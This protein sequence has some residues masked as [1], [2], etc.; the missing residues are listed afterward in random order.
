MAYGETYKG[1]PLKDFNAG[2]KY[3]MNVLRWI[4]YSPQTILER[5]EAIE[6]MV[7]D[8]YFTFK[9]WEEEARRDDKDAPQKHPTP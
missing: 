7:V 3:K 6:Q 4:G 2:L 8:D 5:R 9:E 1:M